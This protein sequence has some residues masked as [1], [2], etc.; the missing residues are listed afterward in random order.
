MITDLNEPALDLPDDA[1]DALQ[2]VDVVWAHIEGDVADGCT[3]RDAAY[4]A[5]AVSCRDGVWHVED[6]DSL[7]FDYAWVNGT[8]T[9][10]K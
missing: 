1:L 5:L 9:C 8:W 2:G 6:I 4:N 10:I 7:I 3:L